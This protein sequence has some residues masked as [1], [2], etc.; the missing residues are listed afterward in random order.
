[1]IFSKIQIGKNFMEAVSS[2]FNKKMIYTVEEVKKHN[3]EKDIWVTYKDKV[4]N[5]TDFV[6]IHP[7]GKDKLLQAAGTSLETILE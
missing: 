7:G 5:V 4:Y 1:M 6:E 3:T 2:F